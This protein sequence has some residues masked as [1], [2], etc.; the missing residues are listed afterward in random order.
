MVL[1]E[2]G[3][4]ACLR[5]IVRRIADREVNLKKGMPRTK[6]IKSIHVSM[7]QTHIPKMQ[8]AGLIKYD[9]VNNIVHLM[10]FSPEFRY[11]LEVI[12]KGDISWSLYYL[13]LSLLG[14]TISLVLSNLLAGIIA[15]CFLLAAI[16]HT[17]QIYGTY[18]IVNESLSRVKHA[19]TKYVNSILNYGKIGG[20]K[21]N[22]ENNAINYK[23]DH[24]TSSRHIYRSRNKGNIQ[25]CRN[26]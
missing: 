26:K 22:E 18:N 1:R 8:R 9:P 19:L 23:Y 5:E 10:E 15:I 4:E 2:L 21:E 25:R 3:G 14:V 12:E 24:N 13:I 7:L 11:Y 6:L 17:S 20:V 16:I